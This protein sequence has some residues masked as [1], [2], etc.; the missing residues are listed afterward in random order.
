MTSGTWYVVDV[1][2]DVLMHWGRCDIRGGVHGPRLS[3]A[4]A[5]WRDQRVGE[6]SLL[7]DAKDDISRGSFKPQIVPSCAP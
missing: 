7:V 6:S 2:V 4:K 5:C 3:L 1:V